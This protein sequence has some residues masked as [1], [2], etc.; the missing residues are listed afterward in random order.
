MLWG[1][2]RKLEHSVKMGGLLFVFG[3]DLLAWLV[4]SFLPGPGRRREGGTVS[5]SCRS[6]GATPPAQAVQR[7]RRGLWVTELGPRLCWV[8]LHTFSDTHLVPCPVRD[9]WGKARETVSCH[10]GAG[11]LGQATAPTHRLCFVSSFLQ[12]R[13]LRGPSRRVCLHISSEAHQSRPHAGLEPLPLDARGTGK[14]TMERS[15]QCGPVTPTRQPLRVGL[16]PVPLHPGCHPLLLQ[17]APCT[18]PGYSR[19]LMNVR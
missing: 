3:S 12:R 1:P 4:I 9:W 16:P 11:R 7:R 6:A 2:P 10:E 17:T 5:G 15:Q 14:K 18:G 13:G 19:C 8:G